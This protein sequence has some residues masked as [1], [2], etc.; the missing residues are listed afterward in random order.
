MRNIL[1]RRKNLPDFNSSLNR[2]KGNLDRNVILLEHISLENPRRPHTCRAW[3]IKKWALTRLGSR[4]KAR[5]QSRIT[6]SHC[7]FLR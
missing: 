1:H 5:L 6:K 2:M 7:D 3:P 4:S